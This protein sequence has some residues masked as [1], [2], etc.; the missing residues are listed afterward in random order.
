[1]GAERVWRQYPV[2]CITRR[3]W[4]RWG[5]GF[6]YA[7]GWLCHRAPSKM[8]PGE[9]QCQSNKP[10]LGFYYHRKDTLPQS[11]ALCRHHAYQFDPGRASAEAWGKGGLQKEV[12]SAGKSWL[13]GLLLPIQAL[14]LSD[15]TSKAFGGSSISKPT[16]NSTP[17][18][19]A[20]PSFPSPNST[21]P[22]KKHVVGSGIATSLTCMRLVHWRRLLP[23]TFLS[24]LG[25]IARAVLLLTREPSLPRR[26][27]LW[28]TCDFI[29]RPRLTATSPGS[30]RIRVQCCGRGVSM[31]TC[32][33]QRSVE[34][35]WKI[36]LTRQTLSPSGYLQTG[37]KLNE[38]RRIAG[39]PV[40]YARSTATSRRVSQGDARGS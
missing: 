1:M 26:S 39:T 2:L 32:S 33:T 9:P 5:R 20:A 14:C 6:C 28:R 29:L 19:S 22:G 15:G 31:Q 17:R 27:I 10:D 12:S 24:L 18:G 7:G 36:S 25:F 40:S 8:V 30:F 11:S 16:M 21:W 3:W 38:R 13:T 37:W 23:Q 34:D 35:L 4:G